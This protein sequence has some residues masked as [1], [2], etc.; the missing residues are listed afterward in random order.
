MYDV[1]FCVGPGRSGSTFVHH[2]L[3]DWVASDI[4]SK[5]QEILYQGLEGLSFP[6]LDVSNTQIYRQDLM[7]KIRAF[8]LK[9]A[10][11]N[12]LILIIRTSAFISQIL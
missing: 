10:N 9:Y 2:M 6:L 8:S 1:I 5:E 7:E 12:I 3:V 11:K 4:S